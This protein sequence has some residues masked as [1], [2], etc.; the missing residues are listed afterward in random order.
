MASNILLRILGDSASAE[1]SLGEVAAGVAALDRQDANVNVDVDAGA[2]E[3][4]LALFAAE[5]EALDG[6][7]IDVSVDVDRGA[8][9]AL[10]GLSAGLKAAS[11]AAGGSGG[12]GGG[13]LGVAIK[14]VNFGPLSAG[15]SGASAAIGALAIAIGVTL[16]GALAA[17]AA[18]LAGAVAGLGA[19]GV[20]VAGVL[21]PAVI[22][23]IGAVSSLTKVLAVLKAEDQARVQQAQQSAAGD[24]Q[25]AAA[26]DR[27]KAAATAL[28]DAEVNAS[29]ARAQAL[30]EMADAAE[31]ARDAELGLERAQLSSDQAALGVKQA[32]LEL[33]QFRAETKTAGT[34][35]NGL[36]QKFTDVD[37]RFDPGALSKALGGVGGG[38]LG[39]DQQLKLEQLVLNV[40]D[41][42]LREK[43]A[44]DGVHDATVNLN[45][46]QATDA[47]FKR[48]GITASAQYAAALRGVRDAQRQLTE[49]QRDPAG[50][51]AVAH[52]A[53]L[54]GQLT[55][56]QKQLLAVVRRLRSVLHD[57]FGPAVSGVL[58]G[59]VTGLDRVSK[60]AG[61]LR[62]TFRQLGVAVGRSLVVV[63]QTLTSPD[64][65]SAFK[66]FTVTGAALAGPVARG[67]RA[68]ATILTNVARASLPFLVAGFNSVFRALDGIATKS[69]NFVGLSILIAR[70]VADLRVWVGLAASVAR[71]LLAF[72]NAAEPAGRAFAAAISRGANALAA[73]MRSSTGREQ[74]REFLEVA[75]PFAISFARFLGRVV[76]AFARL[77]QIIAPILTPLLD[78]LSDILSLWLRWARIMALVTQRLS[79]PFTAI[80]RLINRAVGALTGLIDKFTD[81]GKH[82]IDG[83]INGIKSKAGDI[84]NAVKN[85]VTDK[86]PGFVKKVFGIHSPS[87]VFMEI[88]SNVSEG[89][90]QG[91]RNGTRGLT[92]AATAALTTPVIAAAPSTAAVRDRPVSA[93][94]N[95]VKPHL[96]VNLTVPGGGAPDARAFLAQLEREAA[97]RG[98]A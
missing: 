33:K 35:L 96:D 12:G 18:S 82:V 21:G 69:G 49:A 48:K 3:G 19:L 53:A 86:I 39:Q 77:G 34:D 2:A 4:Q 54:T 22:L 25:A 5:V 68:L 27:R 71:V 37:V 65:I 92:L 45:R 78:L 75:V 67:I 90:A 47:D 59:M 83:F 64:M 93:A 62:G 10:A 43:E 66:Q 46:A 70:I 36:F 13:G 94:S 20:A 24:Q 76:V 74:I 14:S 81:L 88:G 52:V 50:A 58:A 38:S 84:V 32:T 29:R 16:V 15:S 23:A 11:D 31:A 89:L 97:A 80:V 8:F 91:I 1:K 56:R 28:A 40:R 44:T 85:Y 60:V 95:V 87:R 79:A 26:M 9:A 42:R 98:W 72:F 61:Q 51:T 63:A 6:K 57:T 7:Q 17:L 30:R 55:E 73:W 41:A